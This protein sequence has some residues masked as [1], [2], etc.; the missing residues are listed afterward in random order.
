[1]KDKPAMKV[2]IQGFTDYVG[3]NDYNTEPA[4]ATVKNYLVSKEND[5]ARLTVVSYGEA[6]SRKDNMTPEGREMNR[7]VIL[8][9]VK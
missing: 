7:R 3:S 6:G 1:M 4:A 2:E 9:I 5:A 8:K